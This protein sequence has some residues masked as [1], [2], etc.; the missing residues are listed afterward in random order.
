[1]SFFSQVLLSSS[2]SPNEKGRFEL[3][4]ADVCT[5]EYTQYMEIEGEEGKK[6]K[7]RN[8]KK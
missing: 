8:Q 2:S 3:R 1:M 6:N 4:G 5:K 7:K